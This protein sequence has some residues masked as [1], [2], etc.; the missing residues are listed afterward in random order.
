[1]YQ[2]GHTHPHTLTPTPIT[3]R[4]CQ[5]T[6][7]TRRRRRVGGSRPVVLLFVTVLLFH[8][9][10]VVAV[11]DAA[12]SIRQLQATNVTNNSTNSNTTIAPTP[13]TTG[14]TEAPTNT[15]VAP[16]TT[17]P[18]TTTPATQPPTLE[19]ANGTDNNIF[20]DNV[21]TLPSTP[22]TTTTGTDPPLPGI[23]PPKAKLP[24]WIPAAFYIR[25]TKTA[26][27]LLSSPETIMGLERAFAKLVL[28]IVQ[29]LGVPEFLVQE[30]L[31]PPPV[32]TL[33]PTSP[34]NSTVRR[35]QLQQAATNTVEFA[36]QA[37]HLYHMQDMDCPDGTKPCQIVY[38]RYLL[39]L[40]NDERMSD[41]DKDILSDEHQVATV[42]AIDAGRLQALLL[43]EDKDQ[44]MSIW[45][46][47]TTAV[48]PFHAAGKCSLC[49]TGATPDRL[50]ATFPTATNTATDDKGLTCQTVMELYA[51]Q[52]VDT[53]INYATAGILGEVPTDLN[54]FVTSQLPIDYAEY[55][56]CPASSLLP[57]EVPIVGQP[58]CPSF[59]PENERVPESNSNILMDPGR[60]L[61]CG[62]LET[63]GNAVADWSYCQ[64]VARHGALC[65]TEFIDSPD[66]DSNTTRPTSPPTQ[67]GTIVVTIPSYFQVYSANGLLANM[68]MVGPDFEGMQK[69]YAA[70]VERVVMEKMQGSNSSNG[71][72]NNDNDA[73]PGGSN[74]TVS[75]TLPPTDQ[76]DSN[77]TR[78]LRR[79]LLES[80]TRH[81]ISSHR[82]RLEVALDT[83][84]INVYSFNDT[85]C[86]NSVPNEVLC[87]TVN[88]SYDLFLLN[89]PNITTVE[90]FTNFTQE[91][92][93]RG[94]LNESIEA[95]DPYTSLV[96]IGSLPFPEP[97]PEVR[98]VT[99]IERAAEGG[100]R[101]YFSVGLGVS[102]AIVV[103]GLVVIVCASDMGG[104]GHDNDDVDP[105]EREQHTAL[106]R[107]NRAKAKATRK[108]GDG[109]GKPPPKTERQEYEMHRAEL[110]KLLD[111]KSPE[112][113][114]NIDDLLELF[115]GRELILI[116]TLKH[117]PDCPE[118]VNGLSND[119]ETDLHEEDDDEE[120]EEDMENSEEILAA[121]EEKGE[122]IANNTASRFE[123]SA[124]WASDD[125]GSSGEFG[126][127]SNFNL[128]LSDQVDG[129]DAPGDEKVQRE[130]IDEGDEDSGETDTEAGDNA[131]LKRQHDAADSDDDEDEADVPPSDSNEHDEQ[132]AKREKET[133]TSDDEQE[134]NE[135][136]SDASDDEQRE[137]E[138]NVYPFDA[139]EHL[140]T[141]ESKGVEEQEKTKESTPAKGGASDMD[142]DSSRKAE[143]ETWDDEDEETKESTPAKSGTCEM[144]E[145]SSRK[146]E[147]ETWDDEDGHS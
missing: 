126:E 56:G 29:E 34:Q 83:T 137:N 7:R 27:E 1:M 12:S 102:I 86:P 75:S 18:E 67:P 106:V 121:Q 6:D 116:A 63:Y 80:S 140:D 87:M 22:P 85:E 11:V 30:Q 16:V 60:G 24:W 136:K 145:D 5:D 79:R 110:E 141:D 90:E 73:N 65:C 111:R 103:I 64:A 40:D 76:D 53:C 142:E 132:A 4:A 147:N 25:N 31:V 44:D 105:W 125:G 2:Q 94:L 104:T 139:N 99:G 143:D 72:S 35:R 112:E 98:V 131:P 133:K 61:T 109:D 14:T 117:M 77:T 54:E 17:T 130:T 50:E 3:F 47:E 41:A 45:G 68:L 124:F 43:L 92:I 49:K 48:T 144:D 23:V 123:D 95:V 59:C 128:D 100:Y 57:D 9:A 62:I 146:T 10:C 115:C 38:G 113:H 101:D 81:Q 46:A 93:D 135:G 71:N 55:C 15:T 122:N 51:K 8:N 74:G 21:T 33:S 69:S 119:K 91:A 134:E 42:V 97:V 19:T 88:A 118:Y 114:D 37:T 13:N 108:D 39:L 107:K 26:T 32:S 52:S 96:V 66:N 70:F 20:G 120:Y 36:P 58:T 138:S 28:E 127:E 84:N 89:E 82:R 129:Y 78:Y